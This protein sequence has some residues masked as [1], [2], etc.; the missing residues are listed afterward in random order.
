MQQS[1]PWL[2]GALEKSARKLPDRGHVLMWQEPIGHLGGGLGG[3]FANHMGRE[4]HHS[5]NQVKRLTT[6]ILRANVLSH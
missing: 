3:I 4:G 2:R 5:V 6:R 1:E